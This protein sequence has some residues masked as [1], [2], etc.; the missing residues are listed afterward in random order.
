MLAYLVSQRTR[1]IGIRLALGSGAPQVFR[2]VLREG[3][4]IVGTGVIIGLLGS[5][6]LRAT[7]QSQLYGVEP[8]EPTVW[9]AVAALLTLVA[10][11][12]CIVPA[13]R[14]TRVNPVVA[15]RQE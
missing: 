6:A 15:L 9:L 13:R 12:A 11:I 1:E 10:V 5:Y 2:L 7:L 8:L 3:L 4:V 14:A